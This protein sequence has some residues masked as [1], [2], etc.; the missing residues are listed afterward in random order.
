MARMRS[1][2]SGEAGR[3]LLLIRDGDVYLI[4]GD[5][6]FQ[7]SITYSQRNRRAGRGS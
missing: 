3:I 1:G 4:V 7:V 5:H 2:R 6:F